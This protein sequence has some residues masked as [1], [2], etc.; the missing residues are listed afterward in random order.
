MVTPD[1]E[2]SKEEWDIICWRCDGRL[3]CPP[4]TKNKYVAPDLIFGVSVVDER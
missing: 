4:G 3:I 2:L 1:S